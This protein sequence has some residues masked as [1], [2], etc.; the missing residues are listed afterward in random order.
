[1]RAPLVQRTPP[2]QLP[3]SIVPRLMLWAVVIGVA[4]IGY[5]F[6]KQV[7]HAGALAR[8][9]KVA[10]GTLPRGGLNAEPIS[11]VSFEVSLAGLAAAALL[12]AT[13]AH[14]APKAAASQPCRHP[15][16]PQAASSTPVTPATPSA[17][18]LLA[19][20]LGVLEIG[21]PLPTL[22]DCA[23]HRT[24]MAAT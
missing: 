13:A 19:P 4:L 18:D 7:L 15:S 1:M 11:G 8:R 6:L 2:T 3:P 20:M 23:D 22:P 17:N 21:N 10:A 5:H 12:A 24:P 14:A 16:P 9:G